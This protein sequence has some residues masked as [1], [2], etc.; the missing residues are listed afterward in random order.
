MTEMVWSGSVQYHGDLV[1]LLQPIDSV[2]A[3]P[4][5]Y[6]N[7]DVEGIMD[8]IVTSGMY[9]PIYVQRST[10]YVIAGNHTLVACQQLGAEQ[11]P[12][13]FLDIDDNTAIR[14]MLADNEYARKAKADN[15]Q[16]QKLLQHLAENDSL[17][18]TAWNEQE[19]LQLIALNDIPL[20][21][22][23]GD[24]RQW[25]TLTFQVP[26]HVK[27]KFYDM[28][29]VAGGDNERFQL[30]MRLAGWDGKK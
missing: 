1:P 13:V 11:I 27:R 9:R 24:H 25:P 28:T 20:D 15:G 10:N 17:V 16:L 3:H 18:G 2:Q 14:L 21:P 6:N 29:E 30:V 5:N 12:V 4:S 7:G 22:D 26:P 8:S 19:L 23:D